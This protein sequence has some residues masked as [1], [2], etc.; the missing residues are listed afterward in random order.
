MHISDISVIIP[1]YNAELYI[2][3]ALSSILNQTYHNFEICIVDDCSK[4][5]TLGIIKSYSEKY[6]NI[7]YQ[8]NDTNLGCGL[9][10]RKAISMARGKYISFLDADDYFDLTLFEDTINIFN[11]NPS[12]DI[13]VFGTYEHDNTK[14]T[15]VQRVAEKNYIISNKEEA[16]RS[17]MDGR[18]LLQFN[19]NKIYKK[20][21][22]DKHEYCEFRFCEDS[23]TTYKWLYAANEI[24]VSAKS[25]YHYCMHMDSNSNHK[26]DELTKA[27]DTVRCVY[28]HICFCK[29]EGYGDMIEKLFNFMYNALIKCIQDFDINSEEYKKVNDIRWEY[30]EFY[31]KNR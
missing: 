2:E 18:Y 11:N 10:R 20:S 3:R 29:K 28:D 1:T 16:Y 15:G 31:K 21:I 17:Y 30:Y 23:A 7:H 22:I 5:G 9:T 25:Y 13:V 6:D 24:Y 4:D 12:V 26:N 14:Y 27:Y 8:V 19:G